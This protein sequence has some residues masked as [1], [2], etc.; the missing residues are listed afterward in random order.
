M[1]FGQPLAQK[2]AAEPG[3]ARVIPASSWSSE[4]EHVRLS[5]GAVPRRLRDAVE[6]RVVWGRSLAVVHPL[7]GCFVLGFHSVV[8]RDRWRVQP[9]AR[10]CGRSPAGT[11]GVVSGENRFDTGAVSVDFR[12]SRA[13]TVVIE[14]SVNAD[15]GRGDRSL[16]ARKESRRNGFLVPVSE[17]TARIGRCRLSSGRARRRG[18]LASLTQNKGANEDSGNWRD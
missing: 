5:D 1:L 16:I 11:A 15:P 14:S 18:T 6:T 4:C 9:R 7:A 10:S 2:F 17:T 12:G 8:L 13:G 3:V